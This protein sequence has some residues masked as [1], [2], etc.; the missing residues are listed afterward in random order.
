MH[1]AVRMCLRM[2]LRMC[3][4]L[5][6]CGRGSVAIAEG[7]LHVASSAA[8]VLE[9]GRKEAGSLEIYRPIHGVATVCKAWRT[10]G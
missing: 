7:M 8:Q 3:P 1:C 5:P 6:E 9:E 10:E 2:C 4:H